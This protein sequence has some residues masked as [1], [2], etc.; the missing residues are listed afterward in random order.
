MRIDNLVLGAG[1]AGLAY[2]HEKSKSRGNTVVCEANAFPG[3]LCHSFTIQSPMGAFTFDSAV[4]LS[5]T[6]NETARF[7]FDKTEYVKHEPIASNY[8]NGH[9]LKHPVINNL[10]SLDIPD[11]VSCIKSFVERQEYPQINNYGEWLKASYGDEIAARFYYPYTRKY[12][13]VE[14]EALT[15]SWI[16]IRLNKPDIERMLHGSFSPVTGN[17]YYT[18]EMRYPSGNGG[19]ETFL[20]PL[21]GG[22]IIEYNKRAV[23]IDTDLKQ[24]RF[25]DGTEYGYNTLVSSMPLPELA[26][27]IEKAPVEIQEKAKKLKAT[28]VSLV[29]IGFC[30]PDIAKYLW[31]YIY[32]EDILA[33]RVNSSSIKSEG[34]V[35]AGT[36]SLQFEVY[37]YPDDVINKNTIIENVLRS[38][39]RMNICN[40]DDIIF[41]D[42]RLLPCG[43][44]IFLQDMEKDRD[45]VKE[46]VADKGIKLIGRFGEWD[47]LW[48]DQS[49][50]S[51]KIAV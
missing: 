15:T 46:Y 33:A 26:Q 34:N 45:S 6:S 8:I 5:F 49:Y 44:V 47:Y 14:P 27:M 7:F 10:F 37:H 40:E 32:D 23:K 19:Y 28:K 1:I 21:V 35:P 25:S 43:N 3:G 4:H 48:S 18:Q 41:V 24:V 42:Y 31:F 16:G 11:K 50:L 2:A 39:K 9:W 17:D 36:S 13:T 20:R 30:K 38:L 51:G 29:S 22:T 12:W